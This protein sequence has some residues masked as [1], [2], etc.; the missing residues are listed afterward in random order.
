MTAIEPAA[1]LGE[2]TAFLQAQ[3]LID[4]GYRVWPIRDKVPTRAGFKRAFGPDVCAPLAEFIVGGDVAVLC[5]PCRAAGDGHVVCLDLD[6]SVP[7]ERLPSWPPTLTSKGGR[8]RWYIVRGPALAAWRQTQRILTGDGWAVDTRAWGGYAQE[9][10]NG[11]PLWDNW[12]TAPVE[13]S[14]AQVRELFPKIE[15][16]AEKPAQLPF[17]RVMPTQ[18]TIDRARLRW[19]DDPHDTNRLAGCVGACLASGGWADED[20]APAF[21]AWFAHEELNRHIDSALRAAARR[22]AGERIQGYPEFRALTGVDWEW[23]SPVDDLFD[24]PRPGRPP[25]YAVELRDLLDQPLPNVPWLCHAL[26]LAPG[27]PALLSG[28]GGSGKTTFAQELALAVATPNRKLLAGLDVERH[29]RVVHI[30][31][32]Q[33][34]EETWRK[35]V[36]L[37]ATKAADVTISALPAWRLGEPRT[38]A[39]FEA[40]TDGAAL[41]IIDSLIA[42]AKPGSDENSSTDMR[43]PLDYLGSLSDKTGTVFLVVHHHRKD[44]SV[45]ERSAR[46]AGG[47][48]D[49]LSTHWTY[50]RADGGAELKLAKSR[51]ANP[52]AESYFVSLERGRPVLGSRPEPDG[53]PYE[54]SPADKALATVISFVAQNPG[55]KRYQCVEQAQLGGKGKAARLRGAISK[56]IAEGRIVESKGILMLSE[57]R[58]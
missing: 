6:G 9:T 19:L 53:D 40:L 4:A 24:A 28:F 45:I 50:R 41:V 56:L 13:L 11:E 17:N 51:R 33:G 36:E 3:R 43:E 31:H 49:A 39:E 44:E 37:G 35:Y 29:G 26:M 23:E 5:G 47:I 21:H 32:E 22:R 18:A 7:E 54:D 27:A 2:M 10:K 34:K 8:H 58:G 1:K 16:P 12:G 57:E 15:L 52:K 38:R 14:E 42:S 25:F 55:C 20:I 48:T 46:G 30:D